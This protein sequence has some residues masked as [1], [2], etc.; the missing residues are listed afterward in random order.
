MAHKQRKIRLKPPPWEQ[1]EY[2]M[3]VATVIYALGYLIHGGSWGA[4]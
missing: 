1:P 4:G 2:L 3:A